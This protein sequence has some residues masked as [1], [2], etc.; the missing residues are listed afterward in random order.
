MSTIAHYVDQLEERLASFAIARKEIGVR[1]EKC[2]ELEEM[3]GKQKEEI[4]ALQTEVTDLATKK[5]EMKSLIDLLVEERGILQKEKAKLEKKVRR[6]E[7]QS[8]SLERRFGEKEEEIANLGRDLNES[9]QKL[10]EAEQTIEELEESMASVSNQLAEVERI[11]EERQVEAAEKLTIAEELSSQQQ[12]KIEELFA[13]VAAAEAPPPPPPPLLGMVSDDAALDQ[14]S[15]GEQ[16]DDGSSD[17][18]SLPQPLATEGDAQ[19]SGTRDFPSYSE[20][21][22]ATGRMDTYYDNLDNIY[23]DGDGNDDD[24]DDDDS[25]GEGSES[26]AKSVHPNEVV[27]VLSSAAVE[28]SDAKN[29]GRINQN[30]VCCD[31]KE[32]QDNTAAVDVPDDSAVIEEEHMQMSEEPSTLND[33]SQENFF[34][35]LE[36]VNDG[37]G[38]SEEIS[39]LGGRDGDEDAAFV[40]EGVQVAEAIMERFD[41][42][43]GDANGISPYPTEKSTVE[44]VMKFDVQVAEAI[45]E[46]FDADNGDANGISPYPTEKSTVEGVMKFDEEVEEDRSDPKNKDEEDDI[47]LAIPSAFEGKL[48]PSL[49]TSA[50]QPPP[51]PAD[52]VFLPPASRN[53]PFRRFRKALSKATGIHG[54]FTPPSRPRNGPPRRSGKT[55][56]GLKPKHSQNKE[57]LKT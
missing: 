49:P 11:S 40:S 53:V 12:Q 45:M 16:I 20:P 42:D 50:G 43:N 17:S 18:S 36:D 9:K 26:E 35:A 8:T 15:V 24:D 55:S 37:D 28:S 5:H 23:T 6:L 10:H 54:V 48:P 30:D 19:M 47:D 34:D 29:T 46:R 33:P 21:T 3:D 51:R 22:A 1:E 57:S 32:Y 56:F 7:E 25:I 27:D 52:G 14:T 38:E 41:A 44:G 4:V 2:K 39:G 13:R 31:S